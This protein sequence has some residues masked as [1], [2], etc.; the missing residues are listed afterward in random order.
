MSYIQELAFRI[1]DVTRRGGF[2]F[3]QAPLP[4]F[5]LLYTKKAG[6]LAKLDIHE[7]AFFYDGERNSD[8]LM[9]ELYGKFLNAVQL[10]LSGK[11]M[12][13][14]LISLLNQYNDNEYQK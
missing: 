8:E 3:E 6:K 11:H 2:S 1:I 9:L 12:Y 14:E 10:N 5:F 4:I 13:R 7:L